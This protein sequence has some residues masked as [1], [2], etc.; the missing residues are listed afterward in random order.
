MRAC[1]SD[2]LPGDV[3]VPGAQTLRR[4]YCAKSGDVVRKEA[5]M[6]PVQGTVELGRR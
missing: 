2:E 5:D 4:K 6:V 3:D 1:F